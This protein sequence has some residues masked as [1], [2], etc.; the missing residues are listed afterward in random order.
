MDPPAVQPQA[1]KKAICEVRV[2]CW[3][4]HLLHSAVSASDQQVIQVVVLITVQH[5]E[6]KEHLDHNLSRHNHDDHDPSNQ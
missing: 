1:T 3:C 2:A 6:G 5:G 4:V